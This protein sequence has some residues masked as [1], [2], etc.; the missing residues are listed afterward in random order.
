MSVIFQ[1]ND[2][3]NMYKNFVKE[4]LLDIEL[5][6]ILDS[7]LRCDLFLSEDGDLT[8]K[9]PEGTSPKKEYVKISFE[10]DKE[11]QYWL[12]TS[13]EEFDKISQPTRDR[14]NKVFLPSIRSYVQVEK[15]KNKAK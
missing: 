12:V 13:S 1:D 15:F 10:K 7:S 3:E 4:K 2:F 8:D 11:G 5:K 14:L 6:K 9:A